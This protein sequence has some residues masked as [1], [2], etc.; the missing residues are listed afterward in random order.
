VKIVLVSGHARSWDAGAALVYLNLEASLRGLGHEVVLLTEEDYLPPRTSIV[1]RRIFG[2]EWVRRRAAKELTG[3]D[4]VEVAG[5]LGWRLFRKL[6][7][8]SPAGKR[9]LLAMRTHGLEFLD[10]Q[11]RFMEEVAGSIRLPLQY[12]LVT[13]HWINWQ[14][15]RSIA[16]SDVMLCFTSRDVDAILLR[17]LKAESDVATTTWGV[18]PRYF[19][20]RVYGHASG[21]LL[22]WG[23]WIERKGIAAIPRALELLSRWVPGVTLS[24]G[25]SLLPPDRILAAFPAHLRS[26][27][28]ILPFA[29]RD[30]HVEI[31]AQHDV[32]LFPSLSEGFGNALAEAMASSTPCVTTGTGMAADWLEHG[33]NCLLVPM[34]SSTGLARA[35]QRLL[36]DEA[37]RRTLGE[38]AQ[39]TARQWSWER[40][41]RETAARYASGLAQMTRRD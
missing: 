33:R 16:L 23:S 31:L 9:P 12:K 6:R 36:G 27:V 11:A 13:R 5:G 8:A 37:L 14:E 35:I 30:E 18:D 2:A 21:R 15:F 41:A 26:R 40:F 17:G 3:T 29:S 34:G 39:L 1:M 19:R 38:A 25:G 24:I 4:V 20:S 28:T 32:F 10:E 7:D 22:W